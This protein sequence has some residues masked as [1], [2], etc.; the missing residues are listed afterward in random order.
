[1]AE[2]IGF[3]GDPGLKGRYGVLHGVASWE[4][5]L[6]APTHPLVF[7][8]TAKHA[9]WINQIEVWSSILVRK[10]IR[11]GNFHSQND[12]AAKFRAFIGYFNATMAYPFSRT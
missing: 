8:F 9:A 2:G 1:M 11:R 12:L 7:H 4:A 5:A 10:V 3:N 6:S